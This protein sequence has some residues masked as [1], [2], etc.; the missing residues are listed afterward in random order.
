MYKI[1]F[2]IFLTVFF[3][4]AFAHELMLTDIQEEKRA[5]DLF[6]LIRCTMCKGQ[7]IKD[8]NAD[9]AVILRQN[10]RKQIGLGKTDQEILDFL[11]VRYGEKVIMKPKFN[12]RNLVL[13][14]FPV[15]LILVIGY[16]ALR[17]VKV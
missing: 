4:S 7:S 15:V 2:I 9:I 13:W 6:S 8:S 11:E 10:I 16:M 14:I 17:K 1:L 5:K 3:N 12:Y